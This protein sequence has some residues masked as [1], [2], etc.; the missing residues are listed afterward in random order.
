MLSAEQAVE[1]CRAL[2]DAKVRYHVI[3][4]WG[5]DALLGRETRTHKDL[6][7]LAVMD[8]LPQLRR[9]LHELGFTVTRVWLESRWTDVAGAKWPTAFVA[10]DAAGRQLDVHLI[11][12]AADGQIVQHYDNP[13]P[14][15]EMIDAVGTIAGTAIPCVSAAAQ[16]KMHGGY[17]L[18][19]EHLR[20]LHRMRAFP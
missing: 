9:M 16:I 2:E 7:I 3:G 20:D 6:D 15:L 8:D 5:V 10:S 1:L 13:W 12:F 4:G 14:I 19:E 11:A 17:D 18:P